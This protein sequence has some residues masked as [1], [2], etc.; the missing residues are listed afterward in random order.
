MPQ[1]L[2]DGSELSLGRPFGI[3]AWSRFEALL[4]GG[5]R[6]GMTAP[7]RQLLS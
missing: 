5:A 3:S 7:L 2:R 1:I 6:C 4:F